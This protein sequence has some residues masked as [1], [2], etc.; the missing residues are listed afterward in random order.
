MHLFGRR[1]AAVPGSGLYSDIENG[2][3]ALPDVFAF[4]E[5]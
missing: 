3:I 1:S 5:E 4:T 2:K